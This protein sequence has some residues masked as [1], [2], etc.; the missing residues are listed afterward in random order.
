MRCSRRSSDTLEHSERLEKVEVG[1][2][3]G[4][5]GM[6]R[7]TQAL[8]RRIVFTFQ[9]GPQA[10]TPR[11][12]KYGFLE[13]EPIGRAQ[14][15]LSLDHEGARFD[16]PQAPSLQQANH[17]TDRGQILLSNMI[18]LAVVAANRIIGHT[19]EPLIPREEHLG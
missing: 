12:A 7:I 16:L 1:A 8:E 4:E 13:I 11:I 5:L 3:K 17:A 15:S 19:L 2:R 6:A 9:I 10:L 18:A 14:R